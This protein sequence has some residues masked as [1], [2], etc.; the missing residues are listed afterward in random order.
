MKN[1]FLYL[2]ALI[3]T[4]VTQCNDLIILSENPIIARH[5]GV[6]MELEGNCYIKFLHLASGIYVTKYI[7]KKTEFYWNGYY[8]ERHHDMVICGYNED[9]ILTFKSLKK[10]F[11]KGLP[12][13]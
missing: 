13:E 2:L 4:A 6:E 10:K 12:I 3:A 1:K 9:P 5:N 11:A 7:H 8:K